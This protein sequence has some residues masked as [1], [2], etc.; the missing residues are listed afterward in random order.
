MESHMTTSESTKA[1]NAPPSDFAFTIRRYLG[2][3]WVLLAAAT[4]A[5]A[6]GGALNWSWLVALGIAP[7]LLSVLPCVV[8]CG[9]GV[10][11]MKMMGGSGK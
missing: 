8:M 7:V 4:V 10:C 6:A 11:C 9:L 1:V 5:I 3:R 2:N